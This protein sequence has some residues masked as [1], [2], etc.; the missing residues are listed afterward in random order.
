[1]LQNFSG[2][3]VDPA[4]L[5]KDDAVKYGPNAEL[6]KFIN[7]RRDKSDA[8]FET[9]CAM[10]DLVQ[11]NLGV[12]FTKD[13]IVFN[14]KDLP[15]VIFACGNDLVRVPMKDARPLLNEEGVRLLLGG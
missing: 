3:E 15:H 7:D 14:L 13:E 12:Y 5:T 1:M 10:S 11:S 8:S 6:V 9:D 2:E 4:K